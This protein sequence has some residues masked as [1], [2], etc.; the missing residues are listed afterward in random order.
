[1]RPLSSH[2]LK[3]IEPAAGP[4]P[5]TNR[6]QPRATPSSGQAE[7][8]LFCRTKK[9]RV[10]EMECVHLFSSETAELHRRANTVEEE[11]ITGYDAGADYF[12]YLTFTVATTSQAGCRVGWSIC[13]RIAPSTAIGIGL[14]GAR[15]TTAS[16]GSVCAAV[17]C[18]LMVATMC[19]LGDGRPHGNGSSASTDWHSSCIRCP[20]W[21]ARAPLAALNY[22][23]PPGPLV[24]AS[25][26]C[27]FQSSARVQ[28]DGKFIKSDRQPS[29]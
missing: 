15:R 12:Y 3:S 20:V 16:T 22:P 27:R 13:D 19:V 8:F 21:A 6:E 2:V 4:L 11:A 18:R 23:R 9:G 10:A 1:M 17:E 26:F 7:P 28:R 29:L 24:W 25:I 14:R 5:G